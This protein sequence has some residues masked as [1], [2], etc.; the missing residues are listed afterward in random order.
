MRARRKTKTIPAPI[1]GPV[2]HYEGAMVRRVLWILV[3]LQ[4]VGVIIE[5][6]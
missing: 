3:A 5:L 6:I 2:V 1:T 4:F